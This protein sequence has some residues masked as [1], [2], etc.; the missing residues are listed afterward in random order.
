[1]LKE[2][3]LNVNVHLFRHIAAKRYLKERVGDHETVRQLLGH[4]SLAT[5]MRS[6]CDFKQGDAMLRFDAVLAAR[7]SAWRPA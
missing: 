4:K 3:G 6:Y 1:M 7:E 5:T 2:T